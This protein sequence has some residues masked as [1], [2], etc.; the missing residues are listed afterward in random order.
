MRETRIQLAEHGDRR[1]EQWGASFLAALAGATDMRTRAEVY[2]R[3][4]E[5]RQ[6]RDAEAG[7]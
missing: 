3:G 4:L 1:R 6:L 5:L 7:L 2:I